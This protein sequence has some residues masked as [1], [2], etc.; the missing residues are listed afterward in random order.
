MPFQLFT[1]SFVDE[2][3]LLLD[4]I[5]SAE[6]ATYREWSKRFAKWL[7]GTEHITIEYS[8]DYDGVDIRK[9]SPGTRGT[10]IAHWSSTN[11]KKTSIRNRSSTNSARSGGAPCR[12]MM[13][14]FLLPPPSASGGVADV[15][16]PVLIG[17]GVTLLVFIVGVAL[18]VFFGAPKLRDHAVGWFK[19]TVA[20]AEKEATFQ[21]AWEAPAETDANAWFPAR[22][23]DYSLDQNPP[24]D[25]P[26]EFRDVRKNRFASYVAV[27]QKINIYIYGA[28][29]LEK[30]ALIRRLQEADKGGSVTRMT[31]GDD[32][33]Y[34]KRNGTSHLHVRWLKGVLFLFRSTTVD[35]RPF[36]AQYLRS[37][38][39]APVVEAVPPAAPGR[40]EPDSSG[41]E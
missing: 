36:A 30:E 13:T 32:S 3:F 37:I 7:Y 24:A 35:P 19:E 39:S 31:S 33:Y 6:P 12:C 10:T 23:G 40:A 25:D 29:A 27:A 14:A 16:R 2:F 18:L 1:L 28:T 21:Q 11:L 41:G 8:I 38:S 22:V 20:A 26:E 9:L 4:Q 15:K 5:A 17:C 34:E